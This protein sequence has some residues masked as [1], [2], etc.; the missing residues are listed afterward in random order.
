MAIDVLFSNEEISVLGP[1]D[2]I[3]VSVD[4]GAQ[5][6]RGSYIFIG[7]GD[8]N[9]SGVVS[10]SI[11]PQTYDVF[12]NSSSDSRYA[13]MYQ[14]L[15]QPGT[16]TSSWETALSLSPTIYSQNI[17]LV[18]NSS[19][20]ASKSISISDITPS[21]VDPDINNYVISLTPMG[22][23]PIAFT[24]NSKQISTTGNP[25][26]DLS[27]EAVKYSSAAWSSLVGT[28]TWAVTVTVV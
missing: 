20:I 28:V 15:T 1:P 26:I 4:I 12:I 23:D 22:S 8:P 9:V 2:I 5:G 3:D 16:N 24:I 7:S 11:T 27:I 6:K 10:S 19:G 18:F 13:W 25:T 21:S 14:Y 17:E